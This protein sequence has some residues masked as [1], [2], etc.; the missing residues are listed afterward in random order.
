MGARWGHNP[1]VEEA[2][3]TGFIIV[4]GELGFITDWHVSGR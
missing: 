4:S 1:F 3:G 2:I